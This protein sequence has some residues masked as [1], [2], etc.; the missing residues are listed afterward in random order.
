MARSALKEMDTVVETACAD[1]ISYGDALERT[2]EALI[3]LGDRHSFLATE[4]V[5]GDAELDAAYKAAQDETR[6]WVVAAKKEGVFDPNVPTAWIVKAYDHLL[7]AAWESVKAG[8]ITQAQASQLA[9]R[10]LTLGL[11]Q[12][13]S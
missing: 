13:T 4:A 8:E 6:D 12:A 3:P 2:L 7:Y 10:T 9:W 11:R 1:V 5:S